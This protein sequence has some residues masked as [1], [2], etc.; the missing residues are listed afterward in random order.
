MALTARSTRLAELTVTFPGM[1]FALATRFAS[2]AERER[3]CHLI[4]QGKPLKQAAEALGLP[5][6][7]RKLPPEAF[8]VPL[9]HV[10]AGSDFSRRIV[11]LIPENPDSGTELAP[12]LQRVL[13]AAEACH[14][15]FAIWMARHRRWPVSVR[16]DE[17]L[18]MLAAWA[19]HADRPDT[20]GYKIVRYGWMPQMS[21][22]RALEEARVWERR[23]ELAF[24]LKSASRIV[25]LDGA[26]VNGFQFVPLDRIEDFLAESASM[27]NCLDQ[28]AD[29]LVTG[30]NR[31]YSIRLQGRR[32][33]DVEIG[34]HPDD[35]TVPAILQLRGPSN[36]R[37][38]P[39]IWR[40][41]YRWIGSQPAK[42]AKLVLSQA[43]ARAARNQ[44]RE[45][46]WGPYLKA[47]AERCGSGRVAALLLNRDGL[48]RRRGQIAGETLQEALTVG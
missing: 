32:V 19:W 5:L 46:L 6:W 17:R 24:I 9:S 37:A 16:S 45:E 14:D 47:L 13:L 20:L 7:L 21:L 29:Q 30:S 41:A 10:P 40:A 15:E 28:Y 18:A 3:C 38:G 34:G 33:A 8:C 22:K 43:A 35:C 23:I 48:T 36:R 2:A 4:E 12:W 42:N 27:N 39:Q 25:W 1:I 44:L 11:A 26:E 31:V